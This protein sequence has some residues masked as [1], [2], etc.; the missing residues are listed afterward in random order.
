MENTHLKKILEN[1]EREAE[2]DFSLL[3]STG[4]TFFSTSQLLELRGR[5][6]EREALFHRLHGAILWVGALSPCWIALGFIVGS[7]GWITLAAFVL[8]LFPLSFLLFLTGAFLLRSW[9][10][11]KGDLEHL[12]LLV[13]MELSRRREYT[14]KDRS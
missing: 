1:I 6:L 2:Q 8:G 4:P 7:L 9:L 11:T 14:E 13:E 12:R 3:L 5:V 10:G